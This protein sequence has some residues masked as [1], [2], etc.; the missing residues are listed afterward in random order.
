[1]LERSD[2]D[3][4]LGH[5]AA[6]TRQAQ[7]RQ[8]GDHEADAQKRHHPHQAAHLADVAGVRA[9]VDHTDQ[10][11][12][13]SRHQAVRQH[14]QYGAG[15]RR[16]VQHQDSEQHQAAVAHRRVGVDI[17]QIGLLNGR[18]RAVDDARAVRIRKIHDSSFAASGI[19]KIATRKQ[20]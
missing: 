7:R 17:F 3:G 18:K 14:L 13:Q 9:T 19:R 10:R 20:P 11:E 6:E 4:H 1:M 5:E 8:S 2:E 15:H 16:L 12:E